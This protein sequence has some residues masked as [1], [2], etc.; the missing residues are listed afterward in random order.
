VNLREWA[1]E[2]GVYPK[3]VYRWFR[4]GILPVPARG[5]GRLILVDAD[6]KQA[7]GKVAVYCR[8][9]SADQKGRP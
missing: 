5:A 6:P 1:L 4:E 8:V 7:V 2:Q 9:S 3:T